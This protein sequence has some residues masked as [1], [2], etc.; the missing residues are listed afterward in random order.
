MSSKG[1]RQGNLFLGEALV[2][3]SVYAEQADH[4]VTHPQRNSQPGLDLTAEFG[5]FPARVFL[6][7]GDVHWLAGANHRAADLV[8]LQVEAD[9]LDC[10]GGVTTQAAAGFDGNP[11]ALNQ[12]GR[13]AVARQDALQLLQRHVQ[14]RLQR[15][16]GADHTGG[17]TQRLGALAVGP[18]CIKQAGVFDGDGGLVGKQA[19]QVSIFLVKAPGF[20][21]VVHLQHPGHFVAPDDGHT[22]QRLNRLILLIVRHALWPGVVI[23]NDQGLA[24]FGHPAGRALAILEHN[25]AIALARSGY[26]FV[27]SHFSVQRIAK[28]KAG[29]RGVQ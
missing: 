22:E 6:N 2:R 12:H 23:I 1:L 19:Q 20:G 3:I 7:V 17:F 18:L 21:M 27:Y 10:F 16:G 5:F 28:R 4:P 8:G 11:V 24:M 26:F 15:E 25:A 9:A 13:A 14:H 29:A